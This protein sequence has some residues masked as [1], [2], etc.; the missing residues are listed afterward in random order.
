MLVNRWLPENPT[1]PSL[2]NLPDHVAFYCLNFLEDNERYKITETCHN[3]REAFIRLTTGRLSW[4]THAK[5]IKLAYR[6]HRFPAVCCLRPGHRLKEYL[7]CLNE[8]SFPQLEQL[9]LRG[10]QLDQ[11]PCHSRVNKLRACGCDFDPR[12]GSFPFPNLRTLKIQGGNFEVLP[13]LP[14]LEEFHVDPAA[15]LLANL[16]QQPLLKLKKLT[17]KN[18]ENAINK[19][20]VEPMA[21]VCLDES[22][23]PSLEEL[24]IQDPELVFLP[25]HSKL[26]TLSIDTARN[27]DLSQL[28]PEKFPSLTSLRLVRG[29]FSSLFDLEM[30]PHNEN[31]ESLFVR[32]GTCLKGINTENFP[33]LKNIRSY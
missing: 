14:E 8:E 21:L 24:Q 7:N 23:L 11:L 33:N 6:G 19:L 29:T 15:L 17:L 28:T 10:V 2:T 26:K 25:A 30:L 31:L 13:A 20:F 3:F 22:V 12:R 16:H 27:L 18:L 5:I 1:K 4:K 9:D 32:H